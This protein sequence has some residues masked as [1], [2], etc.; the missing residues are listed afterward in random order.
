[1]TR[2][3]SLP[4]LAALSTAPACSAFR[5]PAEQDPDRSRHSYEVIGEA[6]RLD[7]GAVVSGAAVTVAGAKNVAGDRTTDGTGRFWVRVSGIGGEPRDRAGI[8]T[9]PAGMITISAKAGTLCAPE[10]KVLLP[11]ASPVLLS[12]VPCR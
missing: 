12:L 5:L 6:R 1:M 10:T 3:A 11:A 7:T 8:G 2:L 4:L 9:G